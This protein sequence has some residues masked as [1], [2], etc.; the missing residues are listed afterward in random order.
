VVVIAAAAAA[1]A[2]AAVVVAEHNKTLKWHHF[3][4]T[5]CKHENLLFIKRGTEL[6]TRN[7][8]IRNVYLYQKSEA[9]FQTAHSV[10]WNIQCALCP[11]DIL[12]GNTPSVANSK[13]WSPVGS[14]VSPRARETI[15]IYQVT[16]VWAQV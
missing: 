8:T 12:F 9:R 5:K 15:S 4:K 7:L 3:H 16:Q 11:R 14:A 6:Q 10:A 13:P 2:A 1:A